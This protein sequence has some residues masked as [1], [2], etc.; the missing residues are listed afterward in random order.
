MRVGLGNWPLFC[1]ACQIP[2]TAPASP[3]LA[4][5]QAVLP[6]CPSMSIHLQTGWWQTGSRPSTTAQMAA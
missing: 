3:W 2:K 4:P 1:V 5:F 6:C